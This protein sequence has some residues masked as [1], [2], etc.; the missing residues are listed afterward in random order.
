MSTNYALRNLPEKSTCVVSLSGGMDSTSLLMHLLARQCTV[1]GISF[2]YGQKHVIELEKLQQ[3]LEYLSANGYSVC[4]DTVELA[5]LGKLF[6]SALINDA[7]QVPEGF[8]EQENMKETVVPNRNAIFSSIAYGYA[9]SIASKTNHKTFLSLGVHSGDHAIYPDCRPEFYK[10]IHQA[11]SLGNW[12]S[13]LVEIYLPYLDGDKST[14][15]RDAELAIAKLGLDFD[16]VFRNT[17]TSYDPDEH[18]RANGKTGSDVERILA[19]HQVG[20]VDPI[21]YR[22]GWEVAL[23]TALALERQAALE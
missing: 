6:H 15:L 21:E 7:W 22:D 20:R 12:D 1:Y 16:T 3:N 11:F 10:S 4:H 9:L 13:D 14:I 18:G 8:Y 23:Q 19:F 5:S 2:D 17:N